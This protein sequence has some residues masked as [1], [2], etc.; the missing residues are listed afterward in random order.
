MDADETVHSDSGESTP[1][2]HAVTEPV[3]A[4]SRSGHARTVIGGTLAAVIA[5]VLVIVLSGSNG[6]S[7]SAA[8]AVRSAVSS[9]LSSKSFS[10]TMT[11]A[12]A[13]SGQN[14]LM[15]GDGLCAVGQASC[16]MNFKFSGSPILS[17]IGTIQLVFDGTSVY[18]KYP[19]IISSHLA[20]PWI[21]IPTS[22]SGS[23]GFGKGPTNPASSL[24]N[25]LR[26]GA[27]VT[28]VGSVS[29]GSGNAH[30]YIVDMSNVT[31][32]KILNQRLQQLGTRAQS[33]LSGV[34]LGGFTEHVFIDSNHK[35]V[36]ISLSG[37]ISK[38][39]VASA[40]SLTMHVT[41]LNTP[42]VIVVPPASD[43]ETLTQM[44][45]QL[46]SQ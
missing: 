22:G 38:S 23:S 13:I 26:S 11:E 4:P 21:S 25:L 45:A 33:L 36:G 18:M 15:H 24:A 5:I 40:I 34:N 3:S 20:H 37:T 14:V 42:A 16:Q 12:V 46:T 8:L 32:Q 39:G 29:F 44:M 30:E 17:K 35:L 6:P 41:Q 7:A 27:K 2:A 19:P 31:T 10:F 9:T 1:E 28:D 43:V